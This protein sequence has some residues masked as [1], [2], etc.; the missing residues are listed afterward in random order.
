[1]RRGWLRGG[2]KARLVAVSM[3]GVAMALAAGI[4]IFANLLN[5]SLVSHLGASADASAE[6][7]A[8][9]FATTGPAGVQAQDVSERLRGQVV[10]TSGTVV[11]SSRPATV[12]IYDLGP[13]PGDAVM[14]GGQHMW[15]PV[16]V[17]GS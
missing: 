8:E 16:E 15:R 4:L 5:R 12:A 2:V 1:M 10:T 17:C 13:V 14:A 11:F 9:A 3:L 7:A 6:T